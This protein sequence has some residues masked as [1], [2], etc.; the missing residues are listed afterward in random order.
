V[1][2]DVQLENGYTKIANELLV[3]IYGTNFNA[4]QLKIILCVIRY[5]YG[6]NRKSH[7]LSIG[8]ISKATGVSKRYISEELNNLIKSNVL[9]TVKE[10]SASKCRVL[11]LN[12]DYSKWLGYRTILQQVNNTSTGEQ[13]F[14]TT[15]EEYFNTTDE[16]YFHQERQYKDIT[17][18]NI[19]SADEKP[20]TKNIDKNDT[21]PCKA[22]IDYL[23][24]KCKTNYRATTDKTKKHISARMNEGFSL[25]DFKKVIDIKAAEW[26]GTD[27]E[28]YLRPDTLFG[29]KFE[30]YLNQKNNLRRGS[31]AVGK[32]GNAIKFDIPKSS[33]ETTDTKNL[34]DEIKELGLI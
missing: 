2:V 14:D 20:K 10:Y 6:F 28:K 16:E 29:T 17:K 11:K 21:S 25:D 1:S 3:A 26:T 4:T 32:F 23:N 22:V 18:D 12:K 8:F 5:T 24:Q 34:N 15:D 7:E 13:D 31:D 19:Y 9:V 33:R 30:S 27:F